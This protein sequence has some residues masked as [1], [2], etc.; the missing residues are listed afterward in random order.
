MRY[1]FRV[2]AV[3][4]DTMLSDDWPTQLA[5][6]G[7]KFLLGTFKEA[8]PDEIRLFDQGFNVLVQSCINKQH[9]LTRLMKLIRSREHTER[10]S[11]H[12]CLC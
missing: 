12:I 7:R 11:Q 4:L 3:N 5:R 9:A 10:R 2:S 1:F 8:A 6:C